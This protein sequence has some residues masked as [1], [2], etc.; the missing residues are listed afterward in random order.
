MA[1][2]RSGRLQGICSGYAAT[3]A[4]R[5]DM[6]SF[7]SA[8]LSDASSIAARIIRAALCAEVFGNWQQDRKIKCSD[9]DSRFYQA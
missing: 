5:S 7:M 8:A 3:F 2:R 9:Q 4:F 6:S 1:Q